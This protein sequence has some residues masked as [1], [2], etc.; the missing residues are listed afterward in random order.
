MPR[1]PR[2]QWSKLRRAVATGGARPISKGG[3]TVDLSTVHAR[4]LGHTGA[5]C[6]DGRLDAVVE[7]QLGQDAGY[8]VGDRVRA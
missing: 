4:G 5:H 6:L 1:R 3:R 7:V 2:G 8:V